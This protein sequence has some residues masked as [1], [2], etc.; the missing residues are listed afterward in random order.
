MPIRV[1]CPSCGRSGR[2]PDHAI[3]RTVQ[4]PACAFR[5]QLSPGPSTPD[6][7]ELV[8]DTPPPVR[9][10]GRHKPS[11]PPGSVGPA[12]P[13]DAPADGASWA[14]R[15][16]VSG[17]K[18][19]LYAGIAGAVLVG[20]V[21][22]GVAYN[23]TGRWVR[24][25]VAAT[26][27]TAAGVGGVE[28]S[29]PAPAAEAGFAVEARAAASAPARDDGP[30]KTLSTAEIVAESDASIALLKGK[31]SSGTGFLVGPG[32]LATNAHVIDNEFL[33]QLEVHFP[34]AD[35]AHKG[36][37]PAELLYEDPKRDLALL[38]VKTDLPPLRVARSY[39]F[40]KGEDVTVIGSP[41][42]GDGKVLANAVS[43]GVMS[44]QTSLNG[45]DFYQMGVSVN[46]GNSGG[47]VFDSAGRVI[48]VV[49]LKTSE[50]EALAF[51][52]PVEDLHSALS[53]LSS[54]SGADAAK[55]RSR[56]RVVHA[57]RGLGAAGAIY[58]AAIDHGL[59]ASAGR[60]SPESKAQVDK[61]EA[62][63]PELD[64]ALF[65]PIPP[66][67]PAIRNDPLVVLSVRENVAEMADNYNR[68]KALHARRGAGVRADE[69][70]QMKQAHRRLIVDLSQALGLEL[71]T[72]MLTAFDPHEGAEP[73]PPD[74]PRGVM[75]PSMEQ[76][77]QRVWERHGLRP[78]VPRPP[79]FGPRGPGFGP[80]FGP[81]R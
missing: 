47:P 75:P 57:V 5:Y 31:S 1:I 61:L 25:K 12:A 35:S 55:V 42:I 3:G 49:T 10:A 51:C 46:P 44:T 72:K 19:R 68:L 59:L 53:A 26:P 56:H 65:A 77:R 6:D 4:C 28:V 7:L 14:D 66:E 71:P 18:M 2:V 78:P 13:Y 33:D 79:S 64:A 37:V 69:L 32:L 40:R 73:P 27:H 45:Q 62:A 36:P 60:L 76:F 70:R 17:S 24:N 30:A 74:V 48:G 80:R 43:R 9:P 8:D 67:V 39:A 54:Q 63:L 52:V 41:G 16:A 11:L 15:P 50:Q 22:Y 29:A 34:S 38:A 23:A 58:C 20:S 81:R 21:A